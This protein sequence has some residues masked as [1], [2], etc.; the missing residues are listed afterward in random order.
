MKIQW[1]KALKTIGKQ[2]IYYKK[3]MERYNLLHHENQKQ[4]MYFQH[5]WS[6]ME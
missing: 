1:L 3:I 2:K 5:F 6:S 4:E